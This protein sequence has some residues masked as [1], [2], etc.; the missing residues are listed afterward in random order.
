MTECT[1]KTKKMALVAEPLPVCESDDNETVGSFD[2]W[3]L[4]INVMPQTL[5]GGATAR[6]I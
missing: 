1:E 5:V 4:F 3:R 6:C 2:T